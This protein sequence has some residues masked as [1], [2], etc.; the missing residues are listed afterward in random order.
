MRRE[1]TPA[2]R[3]E[4]LAVE[5]A[6]VS[7]AAVAAEPAV[8]V[9]A[10]GAST[11]PVPNAAPPSMEGNSMQ[12]APLHAPSLL[13]PAEGKRE[14]APLLAPSLLTPEGKREAAST[15]ELGK[16]AQATPCPEAVVV[17]GRAGPQGPSGETGEPGPPGPPGPQGRAGLTVTGMIGSRGA[18]GQRGQRGPAGGHGERGPQGSQGPPG[19]QPPEANKWNKLLNVYTKMLDGMEEIHN[20]E[21]K[22][23]AQDYGTLNQRGAL[24]RARTD[25]LLNETND[26]KAYQAEIYH[27]VVS[28]LR[29]S[30]R[31]DA[32]VYRMGGATPQKD[33]RE[34][35]RLEG[36]LL[37]STR[38]LHSC[39]RC[40]H[41]GSLPSAGLSSSVA[42][43]ASLTLLLLPL[44]LRS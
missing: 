39:Q 17:V 3:G 20:S 41:S 21:S 14:A 5:Y 10:V 35:E 28:N 12:V 31:L 26:L 32:D 9:A 34:A 18:E 37:G 7:P 33:L 13:M 24:Y 43:L 16:E 6:M 25:L 8:E 44:N 22:R 38:A 42:S 23:M 11:P 19:D 36:V 4:P 40:R 1:F 15:A 27:N 30:E 29:V 2:A